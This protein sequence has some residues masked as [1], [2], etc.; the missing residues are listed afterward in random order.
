MT[1]RVSFLSFGTL[2]IAMALPPARGAPCANLSLREAEMLI[3]LMPVGEKLRSEG[4]DIS[5]E[6]A[7]KAETNSNT[8]VFWVFNSKRAGTGSVTIGYYEV[9][10][11]SAVVRTSESGQVVSSSRLR[12]IQKILTGT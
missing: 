1:R 7:P 4:M 8:Y 9:N 10:K 11:C 2:A 6:R 5:W 12:A 3:Y